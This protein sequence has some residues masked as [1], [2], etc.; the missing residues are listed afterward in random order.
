LHESNRSK[1]FFRKFARHIIGS[2]DYSL[3]GAFLQNLLLL[4]QDRTEGRERH[5]AGGSGGLGRRRLER[6]GARAPREKKGE[7]NEGIKMECSLAVEGG[8][9]D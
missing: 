7:E 2:N 4:P 5:P 8:E 1:G 6:L 9:D 3:A